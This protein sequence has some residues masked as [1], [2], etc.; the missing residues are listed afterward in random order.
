MNTSVKDTVSVQNLIVSASP[1]V[2]AGQDVRSVM[3]DVLLALVPG[4]LVGLWFFGLPALVVLLLAV[5]GCVACEWAACR[6]LGRRSTVGD[7]SAA[8]TGVLL[9]MNLPSGSPWW[10]VLVG[11][12]VAIG[13]GKAIYGGLGM[14]PFNPA[15][16]ARVFLL[17]S[18]PVQMT[19]WVVP[20]GPGTGFDAATGATPLG[21]VKEA[22][23][24][25]RPL[26]EVD[27]PGT[28][29]L[30]LGDMGG[31]LGEVGAAALLLGGLY[32]LWRGIIRW[33]IPVGFIA[34][35][36][37]VTG[38]A[39]AAAPDRYLHPVVHVL[40]GGLFLGA[41]FMATDMV[42]TPV[43]RRGMLVFGVGCGLLTAVIRLWG[44]YPEGVSFAILLMNAVTPLI[45]RS[46]RPRVFG[47]PRHVLFSVRRGS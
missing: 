34:S 5:G 6:L 47:A 46:T 39:H 12:V 14:N 11:A 20:R 16:V 3:R 26:N 45:D 19:R 37:V 7:L 40:S 9:A 27:L 30:L 31:S 17:I 21:A 13:L 29:D 2:H 28:G 42:T 23:S 8:L 15:L 35:L 4:V 25:G 41:F 1:H 43:T 33:Q 44:G 22:I 24:L 38:I 10:L 36:V 18:F 32:L